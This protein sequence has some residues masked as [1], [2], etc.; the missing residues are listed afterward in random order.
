MAGCI[1]LALCYFTYPCG[2]RLGMYFEALCLILFIWAGMLE[3]AWGFCPF[4]AN[5]RV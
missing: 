1:A 3:I 4:E 2:D 5:V